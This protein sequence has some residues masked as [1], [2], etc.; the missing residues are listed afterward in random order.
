ML[1]EM[2]AA[3]AVVTGAGQEFAPQIPGGPERVPPRRD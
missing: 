1:I 2:L 3:A